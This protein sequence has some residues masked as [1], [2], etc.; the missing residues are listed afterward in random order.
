MDTI[1]YIIYLG[2]K[3]TDSFQLKALFASLVTLLSYLFDPTHMMGMIA[4]FALICADFMF[5]V[6]ASRKQDMPVRSAKVRHTAVKITVYFALIA[7]ARIT[8]YALPMPFLDESIIGFLAAT[9]LLSILE[10]AGRLGYVV[11]KQLVKVLGDYTKK[12]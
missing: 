10:N 4:I 3:M 12:M 5:G 7:C 9:E 8:E 6:S 2:R 1:H 11:P